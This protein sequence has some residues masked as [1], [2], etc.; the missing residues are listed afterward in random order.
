MAKLQYVTIVVYIY[1]GFRNGK[2]CHFLCCLASNF[3]LSVQMSC[4]Y[5]WKY[6]NTNYAYFYVANSYCTIIEHLPQNCLK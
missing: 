3:V 4:Y 1:P 2:Q 6:I 5:C